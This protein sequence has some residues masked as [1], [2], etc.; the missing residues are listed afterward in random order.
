MALD[1][2]PP[3]TD[4]VSGSDS[5]TEQGTDPDTTTDSQ[6]TDSDT[7]DT[8]SQTTDSDT[9]DSETSSG[10]LS[11]SDS[12]STSGTEEETVVDTTTGSQGSD[13]DTQ[14]TAPIG[15]PPGFEGAGCAQACES[16]ELD[17]LSCANSRFNCSAWVDGKNATSAGEVCLESEPNC[18]AVDY[19]FDLGQRFYVQRFRFLSDWWSKR[20]DTWDLLASDDNVH[21]SLV[22]SGKSNRNPWRCVAGEAC[23]PSVPQEC[24]PGGVTQDTSTVGTT[25]PKWDDFSFAGV[26][27]RYWRFRLRATID[28]LY[29]L[30]REVE[31]FGNACLGS[32]CDES[33]CGTGVCTG[34]SSAFC[35]C[36]DGQPQA[37]C[38]SAFVATA[39]RCTTAEP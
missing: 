12:A 37:G 18:S 10:S 9:R 23:S 11:D 14:D 2:T 1:Q 27:A 25:Y 34:E 8:G 3:S 21:F 6:T 29:L 5:D 4:T 19:N 36:S 22:M 39:P 17:I 31:L 24:C 26:V 33:D 7:P 38:T 13:S 16:I 35:T 32:R 15:C 20:P 28:S 30:M